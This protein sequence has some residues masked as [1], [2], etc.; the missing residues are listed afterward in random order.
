MRP[1]GIYALVVL[2]VLAMSTASIMIRMSGAAA[3]VIAFYRVL[4]TSLMASGLAAPA[5]LG[6][7]AGLSRRDL[8]MMGISGLFLAL[9]FGFWI[10]SLGY[11]SISSSVLFTNLQ[12]LF[13]MVFSLI[14]L[15]E[16]LGRIA[17]LGVLGALA[18][19]MII[20]GG[21]FQSGKLAG[22]LLALASGL[23]VAIYYLIGRRLRA[24]VPVWTYTA[25]VSA[26]AA[27]ALLVACLAGDY[28][29]I[30]HRYQDWL[31]FIL[32]AAVPGIAGHG[33]LNWS[34]K[35][36]KAPLVSVSIL[37]E[38]VGASIL[39]FFIFGESLAWY[40]AAGGLLILGGIYV[41]ASREPAGPA[42][43]HQLIENI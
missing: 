21:D 30:G 20:A 18:G 35:H 14:F 36:L 31:L 12:V 34:L 3:L 32:L 27:L 38:S 8:V 24:R 37:G 1:G 17:T 41:A 19:S 4:F 42:Q 40:Q 11:T 26:V 28:P 29:L 25:L 5:A 15:K 9:H 2:G 43:E 22:D 10:T 7:L 6:S 33:A 16:R 39:A 13:V 23:F